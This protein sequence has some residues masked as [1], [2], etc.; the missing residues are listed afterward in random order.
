M[1]GIGTDL[2]SSRLHDSTG[3][4]PSPA[5]GYWGGGAGCRSKCWLNKRQA[6][7]PRQLVEA[8]PQLQIHLQILKTSKTPATTEPSKN[9]YSISAGSG[10]LLPSLCWPPKFCR[11]SQVQLKW[12]CSWSSARFGCLHAR[13][14]ALPFRCPCHPPPSMRRESPT[15]PGRGRG[16][17]LSSA[18]PPCLSGGVQARQ[19]PG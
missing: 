10:R 8:P 15:S 11:T 9:G 6:L 1:P 13:L 14:L 19:G 5:F 7:L 2:L 4:V 18:P 12:K 17:S 3:L 16:A